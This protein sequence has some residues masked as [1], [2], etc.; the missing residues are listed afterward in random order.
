[1]RKKLVG[2]GLV[3]VVVFL[4]GSCNKL[5]AMSTP[6]GPAI[7]VSVL[8]VIPLDNGDLVAVTPHPADG[9]WVALW[10]QKPDKTILV[11][12]VNVTRGTVGA[13]MTIPRK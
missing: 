12:W 6:S 4:C 13:E 2:L 11:R 10:F 7:S 5:P 9:H 3:F 8:P 1:M